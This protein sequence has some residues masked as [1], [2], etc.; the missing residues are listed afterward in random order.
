MKRLLPKKLVSKRFVALVLFFFFFFSF[1][2]YAFATVYVYPESYFGFNDDSWLNF[3][4]NQQFSNVYL[5][6]NW[7]WFDSYGFRFIG[8]NGTVTSLYSSD[9]LTI[10]GSTSGFSGTTHTIYFVAP[11]INVPITYSGGG[12]SYSD[13]SS[14]TFGFNLKDSYTLTVTFNT[15]YTTTSYMGITTVTSTATS[16]ITESSTTSTW[17]ETSSSTS[18]QTFTQ[19][20]SQ[21]L[22]IIG[23]TNTTCY[24]RSDSRLTNG[25][26]GYSLE[27]ENSALPASFSVT[28]GGESVTYGF[29]VYL[30]HY[31]N[32]TTLLGE[33]VAQFTVSGVTEGYE[34]ATWNAPDMGIYVGYDA[35]LIYTYAKVGSGDWQAKAVHVSPVLISSRL[36][37]Q[38]WNFKLYVVRDATY[39]TVHFGS[40]TYASCIEG[41]GLREPTQNEM[42]SYRWSTGDIV[43]MIFGSYTDLIGPV[44]YVMILFI[45][46]ITLYV[47]H[48]N[49]G[50]IWVAFV[51][52]SI[53]GV[54]P[55]AVLPGYVAVAIDA[56][57][58]LILAFLVWRLIR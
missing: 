23:E 43:G 24:F 56:F 49:T 30:A 10:T 35:F 47:R 44:A 39:S 41:V 32:L 27:T 34:S 15:G 11:Y 18:T 54:I 57:L 17:T 16:T 4:S 13:Y 58:V 50:V 25:Q 3:S 52:M 42:Q 7:W 26:F 37:E 5:E 38:T 6:D 9:T 36:L 48:R 46:S 45:P 29:D 40:S 19:A 55:W 53:G 28:H 20:T 33:K 14:G 8:L 22:I 51:L 31:G 1:V 21:T 12:I 2:N